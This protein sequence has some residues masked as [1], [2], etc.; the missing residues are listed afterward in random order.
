LPSIF[1]TF[2]MKIANWSINTWISFFWKIVNGLGC[3][4]FTKDLS[5]IKH[6]LSPYFFG[7]VT[8]FVIDMHLEKLNPSTSWNWLYPSYSGTWR[9]HYFLIFWILFSLNK[10]I[11]TNQICNGL[12]SCSSRNELEWLKSWIIVKSSGLNIFNDTLK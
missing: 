9:K 3:V 1:V 8:M 12:I 11:I 6:I 5:I 10:K 4:Y 7:F 2:S